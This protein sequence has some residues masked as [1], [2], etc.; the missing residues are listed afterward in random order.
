MYVKYIDGKKIWVDRQN[1]T[2]NRELL[3]QLDT[4]SDVVQWIDDINIRFNDR[5]W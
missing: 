5:D 4:D 2:Q 1:I 3:H